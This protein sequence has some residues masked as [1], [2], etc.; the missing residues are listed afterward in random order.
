MLLKRSENFVGR[1]GT[2]GF[3]DVCHSGLA[4]ELVQQFSVGV[5]LPE[6]AQ[7]AQEPVQEKL[8]TSA[9]AKDEEVVQPRL[10]GFGLPLIVIGVAVLV[11][12]VWLARE[13]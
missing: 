3:E 4:D 5:L 12:G 9:E 11:A 6:V 8:D 7:V 10:S 1:D 2:K 13:R